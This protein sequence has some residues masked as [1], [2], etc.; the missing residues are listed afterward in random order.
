MCS[1]TE[2][3]IFGRLNEMKNNATS[4]LK[5]FFLDYLQDTE[6]FTEKYK[7]LYSIPVFL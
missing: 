7:K 6:K 3:G 4:R 5:G 2:I 1:F